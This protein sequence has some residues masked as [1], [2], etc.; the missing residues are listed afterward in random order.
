VNSPGA[1]SSVILNYHRAIAVPSADADILDIPQDY[2]SYLLAQSKYLYL[3]DKGPQYTAQLG[4]WKNFFEEGKR[5]A[6][7]AETRRPTEN[8]MFIPEGSIGMN[9][10]GFFNVPDLVYGAE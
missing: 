7:A 10:A 2:E 3:L 5:K 9:S 6:I 1:S 8:K 4:G